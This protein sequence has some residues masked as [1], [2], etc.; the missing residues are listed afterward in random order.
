MRIPD[1]L[2]EKPVPLAEIK[3]VMASNDPIDAI[4]RL[5][6]KWHW[7]SV[8]EIIKRLHYQLQDARRENERLRAQLELQREAAQAATRYIM[9]QECRRLNKN[10][11]GKCEPP[12]QI[13]IGE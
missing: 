10:A 11:P 3:R 9:Y 12:S 4:E 6:R 5:G 7:A 13:I 8:R 1:E 2:L